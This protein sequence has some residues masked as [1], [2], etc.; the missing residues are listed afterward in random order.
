MD[1]EMEMKNQNQRNRQ[2]RKVHSGEDH[3]AQSLNEEEGCIQVR[4]I[5]THQRKAAPISLRLNIHPYFPCAI[6]VSSRITIF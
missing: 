1:V 3:R 5:S 6:A 2:E 4:D